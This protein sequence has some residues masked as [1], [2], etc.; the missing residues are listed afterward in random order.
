MKAKDITHKQPITEQDSEYYRLEGRIKSIETQLENGDI[1]SGDM[2][3]RIV[4]Q[5]LQGQSEVNTA[6][7]KQI[8]QLAQKIQ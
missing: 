3:K 6:I 7:M 8:Q 4:D 5:I 2:L 1:V